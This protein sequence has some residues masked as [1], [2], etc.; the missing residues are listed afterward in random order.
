MESTLGVKDDLML[1]LRSEIF[2]YLLEKNYRHALEYLQSGRSDK[3][4]SFFLG[5]ALSLLAFWKPSLR[6]VGTNLFR[7]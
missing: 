6:S 4:A 7:S 5:N 2:E 1:A 3:K